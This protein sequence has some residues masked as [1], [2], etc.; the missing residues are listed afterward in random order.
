MRQIPGARRHGQIHIE[1]EALCCAAPQ[2]IHV[3]NRPLAARRFRET[4]TPAIVYPVPEQTQEETV[5]QKPSRLPAPE[6]ETHEALR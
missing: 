5:R 2:T 1:Y 3:T 4:R 6:E